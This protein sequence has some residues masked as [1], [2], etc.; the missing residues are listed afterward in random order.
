MSA[1]IL[2]KIRCRFLDQSTG[3]PVKGV[4]ASL[5]VKFEAGD[6][7][8]NLIPL[9]TL[10]SDATGYMS[11]DLK[12]IIQ[13]ESL[14]PG[15]SASNFLISAP[16]YGL[17]N[18]DLFATLREATTAGDTHS[19]LLQTI[20]TQLASGIENAKTET[21]T[22][23]SPSSPGKAPSKAGNPY[24]AGPS[25]TSN[26][27]VG[28]DSTGK[29]LWIVFPV[30]LKSI[31]NAS[32]EACCSD[33]ESSN[34]PSVQSP[35][36]CD[37]EASPFSFVSQAGLKLGSDGCETLL[38][39][40]LPVQEFH[41]YK[42]ILRREP[43]EVSGDAKIREVNLT[44]PIRSS[45]PV[46]KFGEVLDYRQSWHS[47]G[48]SLGEIKYS[49]PLAPGE[50]TQL[51]VIEWSRLDTA[52]RADDVRATEFLDHD[53]RRDRSIEETVDAALREN[54]D[55]WSMMGGI[56]AAATIPVPPAV[57]SINAAFGGSVSHTSGKRKVEAD[58]LQNLHDRVRQTSAYVR[59]L[60]STVIVQASQSE[61]NTLYT[62]RVANHNHCHALTIQYY[63]VLRHYRLSTVFAGRRRA[64]L[65]PFS[66]FRFTADIALRF[67]TVLEQV[68]L[69]ASL[70]GCFDALVRLKMP[71]FNARRSNTVKVN[72]KAGDRA[73]YVP[74]GVIVK[75][76]DNIYINASGEV[77][78]D[79]NTGAKTGP[80]GINAPANTTFLAEGLTQVSLIFKIGEG[81]WQQGGK[82]Q[83]IFAN[84][85]GEIF[86]AV[87]DSGYHDN[88]GS[89]NV[90]AVA[91][92]PPA[93]RSNTVTVNGKKG[94]D[95]PDI[96]P[97]GVSVR[98]GE[99]IRINAS[100]EIIYNTGDGGK[101]DPDGTGGQ[102]EEGFLGKGLIRGALIFK[103]GEGPWQQG[104]K[105]RN[106]IANANGEVFFSVNDSNFGD[107]AGSWNVT[108][109]ASESSAAMGVNSGSSSATATNSTSSSTTSSTDAEE[110][111]KSVTPLKI[112]GLGNKFPKISQNILRSGIEINA[113][114]K[115]IILAKG[116]INFGVDI[117]REPDGTNKNVD[118]LP[119]TVKTYPLNEEAAWSLLYRIGEDTVWEFC[120]KDKTFES[121]TTGELQFIANDSENEFGDNVGQW[122]ITVTVKTKV[123]ALTSTDVKQP[124]IEDTATNTYTS[125]IA[126][127]VQDKLCSTR[128]LTHLNNNQGYYNRAVWMLAD[129]VERR[130]YLEAAL[131][132]RPDILD[133][134]DD[135]PIAVSGNYVAFETSS[136]FE[137][138]E[139]DSQKDDT[140][141]IGD[142][143]TF[144][145]RG[146]FAE[147]QLGHC[148]SCEKRDITRMWDWTEMTTETPPEISGITP[149]PKGQAPQLDPAQLPANVIQITQPQ[150]AP[151]PTGLANALT[152]LGTPNIFRDMSGLDEVSKLLDQ[153]AKGTNDANLQ[154]LAN[155]A[156]EKVDDL[157]ATGGKNVAGNG[158][159]G[160]A[161]PSES[162]AGK[163]IDK[164]KAIQHALDSGLIN[165]NQ[166]MN[167]TE[168]L[169]GGGIIQL[170][171]FVP[172]TDSSG[173]GL[174]GANW[175]DMITFLP[176]AA[177][178]KTFSDR[179]LEVQ[180]ISDGW[181]DVNLD[182]YSVQINKLPNRPGTSERF[183][184]FGLFEYVRQ[185]FPDFMLPYSRTGKPRSLK[186]YESQDASKWASNSPI[187]S[188][189]EFTVD[190]NPLPTWTDFPIGGLPYL[191]NPELSSVPFLVGCSE[192]SSDIASEHHHW[193][194]STIKGPISLSTLLGF[195][196]VSGTRQFGIRRR[197]NGHL[198]FVRAADRVTTVVQYPL[199]ELVYSEGERFWRYFQSALISF[200]K[201]NG[202][203]AE[204]DFS[205]DW[206]KRYDWNRVNDLF[207]TATA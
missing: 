152:L 145:T 158:N 130:L 151:D 187:G 159:S 29:S 61:K 186:A 101:M 174:V 18:Y 54:Q 86:F 78:Y 169:I 118:A 69:D 197:G 195:H 179:G 15:F 166:A 163:Q 117:F 112:V 38:P 125:P 124:K 68:L 128:L 146:L 171:D 74:S 199:N 185:N 88:A 184:V 71:E 58:S 95:E 57:V 16:K 190:M 6:G 123:D 98:A 108:V 149:G 116:V 121:T 194:F 167:A 80:D 1:S 59:G 115:V 156:K 33:C 143:V 13:L 41:F 55:G 24:S 45:D 99:N 96:V 202:G 97:S 131:Q 105:S 201:S 119:A 83:S 30:Y 204:P 164:M 132:D 148:N 182:R 77:I 62:R 39:S 168:G 43:S 135:K 189:M 183:D 17:T 12:P 4:I 87:N 192:Y 177:V 205:Y 165:K 63:E 126:T 111:V 154:V 136:P 153:L 73:D 42:V 196:P 140:D 8:S 141:E 2:K 60:K 147:A 137:Q 51:A 160:R 23:T 28:P 142:I 155:K 178:E 67:Q 46:I 198:F 100:G 37:H 102:A 79:I 207:N 107:N 122:D 66:L 150:S 134:M 47:L 70:A 180:S 56:S 84:A 193:N 109:V 65:I 48:H 34:L 103:I 203:E 35:D 20:K 176:P 25:G 22:T 161:L 53:T 120:G 144:P 129:S 9:S 175:G 139:I 19:N 173:V 72:G 50:S 91:T 170:A 127:S 89:W 93:V 36:A 191:L 26:P 85:D 76:G 157:K 7:K 114:E 3:K 14:A 49:L 81:P 138:S 110:K 27:E 11:F 113:G 44:E 172:D 32:D 5:S 133:L 64:V 31:L 104:G 188:I 200:I 206:S 92:T 90:S 181:G 94:A 82:S 52:S 75:E 10:S 106:V 162:D 40:T 21:E